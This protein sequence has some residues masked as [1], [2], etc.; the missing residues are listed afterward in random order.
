MAGCATA[1]AEPPSLE[2][3]LVD[4]GAEYMDEGFDT[5]RA[6]ELSLSVVDAGD[7]YEL[8]FYPETGKVN[9][10]GSLFLHKT[11]G[12]IEPGMTSTHEMEPEFE[13]WE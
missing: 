1:P 6:W 12:V 8:F 11:T 5:L 4:A 3:S 7:R 9:A 13:D 10:D 2:R